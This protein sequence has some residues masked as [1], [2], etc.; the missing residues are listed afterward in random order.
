MNIAEWVKNLAIEDNIKV[1]ILLQPDVS[2]PTC[3]PNGDWVVV[4]GM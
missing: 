4:S 3:D 1:V 2:N